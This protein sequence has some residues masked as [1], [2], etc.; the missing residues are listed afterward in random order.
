MASTRLADI[1]A[2]M[3][4][5]LQS[6]PAHLRRGKILAAASAFLI[7]ALARDSERGKVG[8]LVRRPGTEQLVFVYPPHLAQGNSLP[9]DRDSI[10]GR[11]ALQKTTVVENNVVNETHRDIFERIPDAAGTL[12][13]LQKMVAAPLVDG[14]GVVFGV[15]E[16]SRAGETANA[17]GEDFL[18]RDAE[19]L[20]KCCQVFA[21]YIARAC[22]DPEA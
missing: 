16:V 7:R 12:M 14:K 17:A 4:A 20:A 22:F 6:E 18:S 10:A 1:A 9:I 15:V 3:K 19:N 11:V 2:E 5:L 21:P 8:I 13:P